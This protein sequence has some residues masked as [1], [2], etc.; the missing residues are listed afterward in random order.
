MAILN[1]AIA[2][3]DTNLLTVP[4]NKS[5]AITTIIVCNTSA[6]DGTGVNDTKFDMHIIPDGQSR[7]TSNLVLNDLDVAAADT[8]TFSLERVILDEGDRVVLVGQSPANLSATI[9]YLEV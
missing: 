3:T 5:Y 8:F 4:S 1:A 2:T 6:D 9:S 7:S